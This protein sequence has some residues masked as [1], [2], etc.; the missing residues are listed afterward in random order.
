M[1]AKKHTPNFTVSKN[2]TVTVAIIAI[3]VVILLII[4]GFIGAMLGK[5][6]RNPEDTTQLENTTIEIEQES[7]T[8]PEETTSRFPTT[9]GEYAVITSGS[10]LNLRS[11][12]GSEFPVLNSIPNGTILTIT[13]V[14]A[15][16]GY[17][18]YAAT[19][20]WVSMK[21]LVHP[22]LAPETTTVVSTTETTFLQNTATET[23]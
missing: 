23:S 6:S 17:T 3:G 7:T 4:A 1:S 8:L 19:N 10:N 16:W 15:E 5:R 18:T 2:N 12:A 14:N 9:I 21:Y 13:A 20:G 22:S 11:G